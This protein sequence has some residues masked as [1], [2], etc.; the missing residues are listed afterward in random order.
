MF[1]SVPSDAT[2]Y[3]AAAYMVFLLLVLVYIGII[4]VKFQRVSRD[5]GELIEEVESEEVESG[6]AD[7]TEAPGNDHAR[8]AGPDRTAAP[9]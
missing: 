1:D 9:E 3:V 2:A 4:G 7:P 6:Q 5:L 8:A